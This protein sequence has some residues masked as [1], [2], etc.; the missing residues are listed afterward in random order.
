M[1][2]K[3]ACAS[4]ASRP[5]GMLQ[6]DR[7]TNGAEVSVIAK[8]YG[9]HQMLQCDRATNGAEVGSTSDSEMEKAELR[10]VL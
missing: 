2:R 9:L 5:T 8:E 4:R 10:Q 1:A 3:L 6:C 7:A